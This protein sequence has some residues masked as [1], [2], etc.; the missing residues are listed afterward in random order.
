M[1]YIFTVVL[2]LVSVVFK[3]SKIIALLFLCLMWILWGWNYD[4]GDYSAYETL[5]NNVLVLHGNYEIGYKFLMFIANISGL[6]FQ[7]FQI[8]LSLLIVILWTRFIFVC[9]EAPALYAACVFVTFFPL[10]YVLLRNTLS[11]AIVLQGICSIIKGKRYGLLK[12]TILVLLASTIHFSSLF[13][14]SLIF[15][16]KYKNIQFEVLYL[17]VFAVIVI[18]LFLSNFLYSFLSEISENRGDVYG[19]SLIT[20]IIYSFYQIS[21]TLIVSDFYNISKKNFYRTEEFRIIYLINIVL[22]LLIVMYLIFPIS[23]RIFRNVSMLNIAYMLN[24]YN[25]GELPMYAKVVIILSI[26]FWIDQ[27]IF[28]VWDKTFFSLYHYNLLF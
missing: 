5:Y 10:D 1:I 24:L 7:Q 22:L 16:F 13:Y 25:R 27:F 11:F 2:I 3:E 21:N 6:T 15:V 4:N 18:A 12:F 20:F 14:L 17:I 8:I 23:I 19:S 9:S 28:P 26:V